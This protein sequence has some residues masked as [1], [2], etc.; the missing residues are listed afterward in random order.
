MLVVDEIGKNFS[1]TGMDTNVIGFRG[2]QYHED[3][4]KPNIGIIATLRLSEK[5]HGNAIGIGLCD[6][7][8]RRL[9]DAMDEEKTFINTYTTG[10]MGRM[11]IPATLADDAVVVERIAH[12]YGQQRWMF[13]PNTLHLE[14]L[15]VSEDLRDEVAEHPLCEVAAQPVEPAFVG[16][17]L[18][19]EY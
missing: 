7:T 4:A 2:I 11:K 9:R 16:G 1:G 8:T 18:Q 12:R 10:D 3:L 14:S 13:I 6:F 19:L 15:Y 17:R 5:S